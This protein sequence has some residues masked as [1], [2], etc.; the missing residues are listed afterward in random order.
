MSG[1]Q[2]VASRVESWTNQGMSYMLCN[3]VYR[4]VV[5]RCGAQ[6]WWSTA[7]VKVVQVRANGPGAAKD[8]RW[9]LVEGL[10]KRGD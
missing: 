2:R 1:C 5:C 6:G 8:E 3:H 9:D 7:K 4:V 10:E